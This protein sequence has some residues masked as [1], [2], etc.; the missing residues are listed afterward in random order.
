MSLKQ[1]LR[2]SP[3]R[4]LYLWVANRYRGLRRLFAYPETAH[5]GNVDYDEYWDNKAQTGLGKL[6]RWRLRR[7][8]VFASVLS[9]GDTVLD[10]GVGD[11]ALLQYVIEQKQVAGYGLDI[12][13]KAVDFCRAHGLNV[14]LGDINRPIGAVIA[15]QFPDVPAFDYVILS[16]IIE[17][18]P[19]PENLLNSLRPFARK[20]II[21]SIPNTGFHQHR[22]RLLFGHFPLQWVVTPGE[23]L[24]FWTRADFRWWAQ[25][26]NLT[27]VREVPYQGTPLLKDLYPSLFAA[28]FV[29]VLKG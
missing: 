18:I 23:H 27:I 4:S 13:Q 10:L 16:E 17:H 24:R 21:V 25:Q 11:G 28:A 26:L 2:S 22:L 15:Q 1:T 19:D 14:A 9:S 6:S 12:S 3:L 20:G 8:Q 5:I 29:Y 7:A